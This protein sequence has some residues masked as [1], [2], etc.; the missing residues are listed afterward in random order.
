MDQL[1]LYNFC[2]N[3]AYFYAALVF[4]I[5]QYSALSSTHNIINIAV[6]AQPALLA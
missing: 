1:H 4:H 5:L 2:P 6:N 3:L